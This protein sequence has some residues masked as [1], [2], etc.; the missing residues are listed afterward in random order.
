MIDFRDTATKDL[1]KNSRVTK[2]CID[3]RLTVR[4]LLIFV[5][6]KK[7]KE[8]LA[9]Y[10]FLHLIPKIQEFVEITRRSFSGSFIFNSSSFNYI[11]K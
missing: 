11:V 2:C 6:Q 9:L 1:K 10:I 5:I 8:K 7:K 4:R 3:P